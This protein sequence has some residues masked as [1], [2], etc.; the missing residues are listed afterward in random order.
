M[1]DTDELRAL[2]DDLTAAMFEHTTNLIRRERWLMQSTLNLDPPKIAPDVLPTRR[3]LYTLN[4]R[5]VIRR[6]RDDSLVES[7]GRYLKVTDDTI[8][9]MNAL[10][11][12]EPYDY[13]D[14]QLE[15]RA[16]SYWQAYEA[17]VDG[18]KIVAA[19]RTR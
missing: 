17:F 13:S 18:S 3:T 7:L 11:Y 16:H 6:G 8:A 1:K 12:P 4:A 2:L 10:D 14:E 15:Q 9:E 5:L 19:S